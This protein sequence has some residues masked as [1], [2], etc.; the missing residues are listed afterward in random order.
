MFF[1]KKLK[2]VRFQTTS[3]FIYLHIAQNWI[4]FFLL[5]ALY[6]Q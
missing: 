3:S 4:F 1:E 6:Q 5:L 2:Q